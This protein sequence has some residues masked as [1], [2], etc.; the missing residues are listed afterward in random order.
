MTDVWPMSDTASVESTEK[1]RLLNFTHSDFSFR[2]LNDDPILAGQPSITHRV[3]HYSGPIRSS[4]FQ[5]KNLDLQN[6]VQ[7]PNWHCIEISEDTGTATP[8]DSGIR[9]V[10]KIPRRGRNMC[11]GYW[12][13]F[14]EEA[15]G[16]DQITG[17][18]KWWD[19]R[20]FNK[21]KAFGNAR[22][23][24]PLEFYGHILDVEEM[25]GGLKFN[26]SELPEYGE[27]STLGLVVVASWIGQGF[28]GSNIDWT[29]V[30]E[31]LSADWI[32]QGGLELSDQP[33]CTIVP[34]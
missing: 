2:L 25:E 8:S 27:P 24:F 15:W 14:I 23:E 6:E 11:R 1:E 16:Q 5:L 19:T 10:L 34:H 32:E 31:G 4:A 17:Y 7:D 28:K 21:L 13:Q 30:A 20:I 12:Q 3:T 33:G 29:Q 22:V 26:F 9:S 18:R